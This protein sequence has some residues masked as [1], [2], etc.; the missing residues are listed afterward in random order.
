MT[1]VQLLDISVCNSVLKTLTW[2]I[3][4]TIVQFILSTVMC[5]LVMFKFV[6]DLLHMH[7]ATG[8]WELNRYMTLLVSEG[9]LYFLL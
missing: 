7:Q 8:K 6:R 2:N 5:I 1:I 9:L 3:L 4:L